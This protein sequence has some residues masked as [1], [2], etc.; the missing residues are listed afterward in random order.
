MLVSIYTVPLPCLPHSQLTLVL[1][2]EL[3]YRALAPLAA[4]VVIIADELSTVHHREADD[5]E[6]VFGSRLLRCLGRGSGM[7]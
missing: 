1:S 4:A 6:V 7:R 5:G 2:E 3:S